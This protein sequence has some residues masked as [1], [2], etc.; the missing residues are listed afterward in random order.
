MPSTQLTLNLGAPPPPTLDNFVVGNNHALIDALKALAAGNTTHQAIYWWGPTGSGCSHLLRACAMLGYVQDDC[1]AM[2]QLAQRQA[3]I[4]FTQMI[5][6][7]KKTLLFA[8]DRAPQQLN[9]RADLQTRLSQCLV[10]EVQALTDDDIALALALTIAERGVK[11]DPG[12][13]DFLLK[14]ERRDMGTLRAIIDRLDQFSLERKK[15]I[16]LA[17][18]REYLEGRI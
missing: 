5:A 6:D 12:L 9:L 2:D 15:P 11:A 17:L 1:Q 4:Q 14:H 16:S 10:F 3:F 13:I 8:A 18:A 7:P